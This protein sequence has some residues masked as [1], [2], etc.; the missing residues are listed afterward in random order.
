MGLALAA[1]AATLQESAAAT[2]EVE[3]S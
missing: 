1:D 2:A 3:L